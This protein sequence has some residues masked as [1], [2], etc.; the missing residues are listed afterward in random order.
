MSLSLRW[1]NPLI[2]VTITGPHEDA[3]LSELLTHELLGPL[4]AFA[5]SW[6]WAVGVSAYSQLAT[7]Y[8]AASVNITRAMV[9]L[10]VAIIFGLL[11]HGGLFGLRDALAAVSSTRLL[12]L[13]LAMFSGYAFGDVLFLM[14]TRAIG[15]PAALAIASCYPFWSALAGFIFL[16]EVVTLLKSI[17]ITCTVGGTILVI[18]SGTRSLKVGDQTKDRQS[19][20]LYLRG[21]ILALLTS[22]LWSINA[23]STTVGGRGLS[24]AVA[25]ITRLGIAMVLCPVVAA[26]MT[27]R[28]ASP[29][30][31]VDLRRFFLV[32][33]IEGFGGAT[34]YM[35]GLAHSSV[36]A[37]SA[38]SAL[39]PAIAAPLAWLSG[40]E[41]FSMLRTAGILLALLGVILLMIP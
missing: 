5:S 23:Y 19:K 15:A 18:L 28:W 33:L 9:A 1:C 39:S 22:G 6:T 32:F 30:A 2:Y 13:T 26:F 29:V 36:A 3:T 31:K 7:R 37:G 27:R 24:V 40:A 4:A 14:S 17:G 21:V 20:Q 34:L 16:G 11:T 10:P 41:R 35:Y 12:W 8:P 25:T 38:L